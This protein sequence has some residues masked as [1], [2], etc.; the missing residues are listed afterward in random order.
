M[1]GDRRT[2]ER[3]SEERQKTFGG[4]RPTLR[5]LRRTSLRP[6][7]LGG[8]S[9]NKLI[10]NILTMLALA[11]G[12]TGMRFAIQERWEAAV[13]AILIAG[14]LD[15][16]DG[17]LARLLNAQSKFGA[18]LDSLADMVSF[19][20]APAMIL[21]MWALNTASNF[22]WI[23]ALLYGVCMA[24]RLARFN[25]M[26]GTVEKPAW[27]FNYFTGVPAPAAAGLALVPMILQFQF[28][29]PVQAHPV[30]VA[31]WTTLM[32]TLMISTVPT[33][34]FK[35]LKIPPGRV[36]FLLLGVGVLAAALVG[37]PWLTLLG[38]GAVYLAAIPLSI[39]QYARLKREAER[40][41]AHTPDQ[42]AESPPQA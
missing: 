15:G 8:V 36:V 31:L 19:G 16:L 35:G 28:E 39:R 32:A 21:Y 20:I 40:L 5:R 30:P 34:S 26:M 23:A 38:I 42:A 37:D 7:R 3:R 14:V 6:P 13:A 12:M 1:I 29:W 11:V 27:A 24:L 2:S 10:P 4:P 33:F 9:V 41:Q 22:G 18:E 17:R 25:T